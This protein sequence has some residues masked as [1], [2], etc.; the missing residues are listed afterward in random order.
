MPKEY[1]V[2][3]NNPIPPR[4]EEQ[5][6][7]GTIPFPA[8]GAGGGIVVYFRRPGDVYGPLDYTPA[9]RYSA[10]VALAVRC[11]LRCI[12]AEQKGRKP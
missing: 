5:L 11:R 1:P 9:S 2:T 8:I 10:T 7:G 4:F 12:M 6:E 3:R